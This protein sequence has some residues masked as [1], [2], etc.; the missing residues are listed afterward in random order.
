MTCDILYTYSY[1]SNIIYIIIFMLDI[2]DEEI[3]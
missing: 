3:T 2:N 1:S